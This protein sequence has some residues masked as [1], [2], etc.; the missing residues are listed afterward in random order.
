M[1]Q[2]AVRSGGPP[3]R[4]ARARKK[5][6]VAARRRALQQ[7]IHRGSGSTDS[8]M[9]RR[10][11]YRDRRPFPWTLRVPPAA[12]IGASSAFPTRSRSTGSSRRCEA[13]RANAF[14]ARRRAWCHGMTI[15][16]SG[17]TPSAC[18]RGSSATA[19]RHRSASCATHARRRSERTRL[20]GWN[21]K[22]LAHVAAISD[23]A[24]TLAGRRFM[25]A[26]RFVAFRSFFILLSPS[27]IHPTH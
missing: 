13:H 25:F 5:T 26:T 6:P 10:P 20:L 21:G 4:H 15:P 19:D 1:I 24:T 8:T 23:E 11:S 7:L 18:V 14:A 12:R 16:G 9:L 3:P 22:P 2:N 27:P 17:P